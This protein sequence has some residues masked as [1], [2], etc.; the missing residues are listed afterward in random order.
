MAATGTNQI[1]AQFRTKEC[2]AFTLVELLVVICI[3]MVLGALL[4]GG[5]RHVHRMAAVKETMAELRVCQGM[6]REYENINGLAG[7]EAYTGPQLAQSTDP[8]SPP[9]PD[10][11]SGKFPV[12][13]DPAPLLNAAA[14]ATS[15]SSA[16]TSWPSYET[17]DVTYNVSA[18]DTTATARYQSSAVLFTRQV[19]YLLMRVPANRV[20]VQSVQSKRILEAAPGQGPIPLDQGPILLD[21]WGNPIIFVPRGGIHIYVPDSSNPSSST[22]YLVRSTGVFRGTATDPPLTGN[23][24]PFWASA[25]EDGDFTLGDDNLYSFQE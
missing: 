8:D 20:T 23:E 1:S 13:V 5:V 4:I 7:I 11:K 16:G 9:G 25:G 12:F 2:R 10:G 19:M 21:G 17:N 24:R 22:L 14:A 18:M 6:L 15:G 3:I